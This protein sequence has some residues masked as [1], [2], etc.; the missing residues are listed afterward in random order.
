MVRY[1]SNISEYS[2]IEVNRYNH[3][4]EPELLQNNSLQVEKDIHIHTNYKVMH[5]V[6]VRGLQSQSYFGTKLIWCLKTYLFE[7]YTL[8]PQGGNT[9][10][11]QNG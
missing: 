1:L 3:L 2:R 10:N 4:K 9:K 6:I 11:N 8:K 7:L 5:G